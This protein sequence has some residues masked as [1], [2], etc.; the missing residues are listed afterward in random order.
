M[1]IIK[2][3]GGAM[4]LRQVVLASRDLAKTVADIRAVFDVDVSFH[5]PGV[6]AFGL[7]NAVMPVGT[8]FL[9]VVSPVATGT[10]AGRFLD[11]RGGDGG[12]MVML[13]TA[14]HAAARLR[15]EEGNVRVVFS[16]D[17]AEVTEI[18]LHPSDV[19]GAIVAISKPRPA[20]SW[21]WGGPDWERFVRTEIVDRAVGVELEAADPRALAERWAEVLGLSSHRG[22]SGAFELALDGGRIRFVPL[23]TLSR[24]GIVAFEFRTNDPERALGAAARRGLAVKTG[25][26]HAAVAIAGVWLR[27]V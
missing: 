9:E 3:R 26:G 7:R 27:L 12:Y 20:S 11:R 21:K 25:H 8:T 23:E 1:A 6:G 18:H 2:A 14:D 13:Q 17:L 15:V 4:I 10:A 5:D 24:D 22:G 16:L 19:P